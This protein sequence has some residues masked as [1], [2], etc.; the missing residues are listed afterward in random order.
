MSGGELRLPARK[1]SVLVGGLARRLVLPGAALA[2]MLGRG[3]LGRRATCCGPAV[4]AWTPA[5]PHA[6]WSQRPPA[7]CGMKIFLWLCEKY[8]S[9]HWKYF[10]S[11]R[12]NITTCKD[13]FAFQRC[14]AGVTWIEQKLLRDCVR[15]IGE[16]SVTHHEDAARV[17]AGA[18]DS[19]YRTECAAAA[20]RGYW[21]DLRTE[22]HGG[23]AQCVR[24]GG[25][26]RAAR[27]Q[28]GHQAGRAAVDQRWSN[29]FPIVT[30]IFYFRC[31]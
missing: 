31:K 1:L 16:A 21:W 8:F 9:L 15:I 26:E 5:Q 10:W 25:A 17:G 20:G 2:G 19:V 7:S 13:I 28:C 12:Y 4:V 30:N 11:S 29:I 18:S 23:A 22:V 6:R 27:L 14:D 3:G 24:A